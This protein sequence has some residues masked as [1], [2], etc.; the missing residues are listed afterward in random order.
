MRVG[1]GQG[2]GT[3]QRREGKWQRTDGVARGGQEGRGPDREAHWAGRPL[4]DV[5]H[6]LRE[7]EAGGRPTIKIGLFL[8]DVWVGG[9]F[10]V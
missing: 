5:A 8:N 9:V 6:E 4:T 10:Q 3:E 2:K 1:R 7:E